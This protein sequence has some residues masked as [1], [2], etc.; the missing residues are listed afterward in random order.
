MFS[1][2]NAWLHLWLGIGSGIIVLIISLTGAMLVFESEITSMASPWLHASPVGNQPQLPPSVLYK[3]VQQ[4]MPGKVINSIWY[5]GPDRTALVSIKKSDSLV[6]V[7]PYNAK[8]V[9]V[10]DHE[11]FFHIIEEGHFHLW[12]PEE[13]GEVL[14]GWGTFIFFFLLISGLILWYPKKW[15]KANRNKSFKVK[16]N[17]SFKR[18]NY[19]LHNVLGFYALIVALLLAFTGLCMS[20]NW[21]RDGVYWASGGEAEVKSKKEQVTTK[22]VTP[23]NSIDKLTAADFI[24]N[25]LRTQIARE[26]KEAVIISFNEKPGDNIYACTDMYKG[27]WRDLYFSPKTLKLLPS[28]Q[29]ALSD[30]VFANWLRRSNFTLHTGLIGGLTTKIIYFTASIICASLPVTGFLV[31]WGKK[32]KKKKPAPKKML[33]AK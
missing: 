11:N 3:S 25:K 4:Q 32:K 29:I 9:A 28:T 15:N 17:A 13:I 24:W 31:W 18:L 7:N 33:V 8:L 26:N 10:V 14:T 27:T 1:K 20:F 2:I 21:F 30:E 19:D 12:L 23:G 5:N 6:Y 22:E 16:W